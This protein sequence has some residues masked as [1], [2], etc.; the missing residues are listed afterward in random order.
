MDGVY[1]YPESIPPQ[2]GPGNSVIPK[3]ENAATSRLFAHECWQEIHSLFETY[4]GG[5]PLVAPSPVSTSER[6]PP[7]N[8][9]TSPSRTSNRAALQWAGL[10]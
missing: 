6:S 2:P 7:P 10:S 9:G 8:G 3:M 5:A 4:L 1:P